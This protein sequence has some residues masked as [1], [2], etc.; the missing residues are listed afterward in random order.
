MA[1]EVKKEVSRVD[2]IEEQNKRL[3]EAVNRQKEL[4][5]QYEEINHRNIIGGQSEAGSMKVPEIS[6]A[7]KIKAEADAFVKN[8]RSM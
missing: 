1:D 3:E 8:F 7:D 2:M 5:K 4:L 6:E